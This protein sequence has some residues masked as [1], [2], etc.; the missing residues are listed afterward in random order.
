M[1]D[2]LAGIDCQ[3]WPK[4]QGAATA[5]PIV[6]SL[7]ERDPERFS[8]CSAQAAGLLFDYSRQR[9]DGA[10]LGAFTTLAEQLELRAR[11]EAMFSG[12]PINQTEGRAVLHTALRRPA[13]AGPL[14]VDGTDLQPLILAE[15]KHMLGFA[16]AI[17]GGTIRSSKNQAFNL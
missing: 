10:L 13:N 8:H 17:R 14:L 16:D 11:T 7:F 2:L 3:I 6:R 1:S 9:V 12:A 15:R 5:P 4:L